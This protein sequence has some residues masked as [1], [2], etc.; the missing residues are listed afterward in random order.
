MALEKREWLYRLRVQYAADG[1]VD[2]IE[3][4]KKADIYDGEQLVGKAPEVV[5]TFP[6]DAA[7]L[8]KIDAV[9]ADLPRVAAE[10]AERKA[11][12]ARVAAAE[13]AARE[14]EAA[15]ITTDA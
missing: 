3:T 7:L 6:A 4:V 8:A 10:E 13:K 9:I 15:L 2:L 5:E 11:E 12:A 1:R 14:A